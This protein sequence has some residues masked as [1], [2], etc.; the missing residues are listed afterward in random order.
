MFYQ[1]D[2]G[3]LNAAA[4]EVNQIFDYCNEVSAKQRV[5]RVL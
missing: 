5:H 4:R 2:Y 3:W 1:D